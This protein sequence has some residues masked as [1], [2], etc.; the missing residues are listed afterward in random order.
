MYP[1]ASHYFLVLGDGDYEVALD[2][3]I[4]RGKFVHVCSR[5]RGEAD[6]YRQFAQRYPSQVTYKS[7]EDILDDSTLQ[8]N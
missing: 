5:E 1:N 4:K 3:L 7:L 6:I 8:P 2:W